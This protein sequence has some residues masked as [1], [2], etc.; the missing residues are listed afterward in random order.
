MSQNVGMYVNKFAI[1]NFNAR[2]TSIGLRNRRLKI[3]T[4]GLSA[5]MIKMSN[6]Y[7]GWTFQDKRGKG[8]GAS[9]PTLTASPP[10]PKKKLNCGT[11]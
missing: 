11:F 4:E 3:Q 8:G 9:F 6:I 10:K 1:L 5:H 7:C 2:V